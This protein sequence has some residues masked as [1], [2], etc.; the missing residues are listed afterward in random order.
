MSERQMFGVV[1]WSDE[2]ENKAVIW[3]EDHGNLAFYTQTEA[4]GV[5]DLSIDAG[6]LIQFDLREH[7]QMRF[8]RNLKL[9]SEDQFPTIADTLTGV[10]NRL[11]GGSG[12]FDR[13]AGGNIIPMEMRR[14]A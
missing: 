7:Q 2:A 8:A 1:L 4:A 13:R 6:D 12:R 11:N 3:C 9:V 5:A 14:T 10:R